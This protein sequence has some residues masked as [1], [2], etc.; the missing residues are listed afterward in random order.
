MAAAINFWKLSP[1]D[2]NVGQCGR[3]VCAT[4]FCRRN[5]CTKSAFTSLGKAKVNHAVLGKVGMQDHIAQS[6]LTTI[7]DFRD[8]FDFD[9]FALGLPQHQLTGLFGYQRFVQLG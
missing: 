3:A 9:D 7:S 1:D 4:Q 8:T 2:F 5:R 6:A